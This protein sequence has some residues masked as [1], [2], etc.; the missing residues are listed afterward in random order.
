VN[1]GDSRAVACDH[2]GKVFVLSKDHKPSDANERHRI[3]SAGGFIENYGVDRVQGVL[4]VTRAFGDTHLKRED[5]I[6][7]HPDIVRVDLTQRPLRYIIVASDGLFDVFENQEAID[8]ANQYLKVVGTNKWTK[9]AEAFCTEA[10]NRGSEDNV[11]VLIIKLM[12]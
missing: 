10:L 1:V 4:A 11:S 5:V 3:E 6:T 8:F 9:L 12:L 7:A 2:N